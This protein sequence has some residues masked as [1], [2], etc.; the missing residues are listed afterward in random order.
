MTISPL[1]PIEDTDDIW[2]FA[3]GADMSEGEVGF[4]T[5]QCK[6]MSSLF[7]TVFTNGTVKYEDNN[8]CCGVDVNDP[9]VSFQNKLIVDV[10]DD[11]YPIRIPLSDKAGRR[12]C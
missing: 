2:N 5:Y 11:M 6:R 9:D 10:V 4:S 1:T 7:K 8:R 12:T 3:F